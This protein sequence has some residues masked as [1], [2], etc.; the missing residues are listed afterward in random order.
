MGKKEAVARLYTKDENEATVV[1]IARPHRNYQWRFLTMFLTGLKKLSNLDRPS[2]YYRVLFHALATLDPVQFRSLTAREVSE[3]TDMSLISAQRAITMLRA[4][5]VL[6]SKGKGSALRYRMNNQ[7][8]WASTA[9]KHNQA[10]PD[11]DLIDGRK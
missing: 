7:V 4:D 11:Q 6:I 3:S 2:V 10:M 8:A 5:K 1:L 9:E